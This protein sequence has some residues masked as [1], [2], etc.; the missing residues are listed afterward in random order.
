MIAALSTKT[1]AKPN[2][3]TK[4]EQ[5]AGRGNSSAENRIPARPKGIDHAEGE[6]LAEDKDPK[7]NMDKARDTKGM[8][9]TGQGRNDSLEKRTIAVSQT[10]EA[11]ESLRYPESRRSISEDS[12]ILK[13][14]E[15]SQKRTETVDSDDIEIVDDEGTSELGTRLG[16]FGLGLHD[17]M[18]VPEAEKLL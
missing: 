5:T 6:D 3:Y 7:D 14:T 4:Y 11:P 18:E 1:P 9:D 13:E 15:L 16:Y 8:D 12:V 2:G 17:Q 10:E